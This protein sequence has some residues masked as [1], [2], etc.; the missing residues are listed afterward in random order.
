MVVRIAVLVAAATVATA[1]AAAATV[2]AVAVE[3]LVALAALDPMALSH[4]IF[5]CRW[6]AAH[7]AQLG[8]E[9]VL[10]SFFDLKIL[11]HSEGSRCEF[12]AVSA[13]FLMVL[14]NLAIFS[15]HSHHL[16]HVQELQCRYLFV[17]FRVELLI[18]VCQY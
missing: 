9:L 8:P 3:F 2:V 17:T 5:R 12:A 16:V 11:F 1:A 7:V 10:F 13:K 4:W 15:H 18:V 14:N 6:L